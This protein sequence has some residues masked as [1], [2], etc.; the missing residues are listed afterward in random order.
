LQVG[1]RRGL[2]RCSLRCQHRT[3]D[4]QRDTAV[5]ELRPRLD[6]DRRGERLREG[7]DCA[8]RPPKPMPLVN[9]KRC[10]KVTRDLRGSFCHSGTVRATSS[11]RSSSRRPRRRRRERP[12]NFSF[13]C[14]ARAVWDDRSRGIALEHGLAAVRDDQRVQAV[15][16]GIGAAA[17]RFT[18][19]TRWFASDPRGD[20]SKTS[21]PA[22]SIQS[23]ARSAA[24]LRRNGPRQANSRSRPRARSRSRRASV[25]RAA[26]ATATRIDELR[27]NRC[28]EHDRLRIRNLR[29]ES[30]SASARRS[31]PGRN[32]ADRA[33][34]PASQ[35]RAQADERQIDDPA[36]LTSVR[37]GTRP[38]TTRRSRAPRAR[39]RACSRRVSRSRLQDRRG[40]RAVARTIT[41]RDRGAGM[42]QSVSSSRTKARASQGLMLVNFAQ[43]VPLTPTQFVDVAHFQDS[44]GSSEAMIGC[45][46]RMESLV[47][48]LFF[49]SSQHPTWPHS[50]H[51]RK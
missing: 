32:A 15:F 27:Q 9:C 13:R 21:P 1:V 38:A 33:P 20:P 24:A 50:R 42:R 3:E 49:E 41:S 29:D 48:C 43:T 12:K 28:E 31:S 4:L 8:A 30:R 36:H 45:F 37:L 35:Q 6:F 25:S 5:G 14:R 22:R 34:R 44:P 46:R 10:R 23:E 17:S 16:L 11:S 18:G 2:R 26:R 40:R 19:V 7:R 47:A 39:S 51:T